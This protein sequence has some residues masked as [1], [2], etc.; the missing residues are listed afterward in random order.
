MIFIVRRH[1]VAPNPDR[2]ILHERWVAIPEVSRYLPSHV[3]EIS[4]V[5]S[6]CFASYELVHSAIVDD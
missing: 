5:V 3:Q 4:M 6:G 2:I 1:Q